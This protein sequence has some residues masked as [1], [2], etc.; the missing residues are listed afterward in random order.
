MKKLE[1]KNSSASKKRSASSKTTNRKSET[2]TTNEKKTVNKNSYYKSKKKT[3]NV[4]LVIFIIIAVIIIAAIVLLFT[5]PVFKV[6]SFT[7]EGT[8]KYTVDEIV[9][10]SGLKVN[11]NIFFQLLKGVS[12][13]INE[14]PYVDSAS[15]KI[16][17]PNK[18]D[19]KIKERTYYFFAFDKEK[20]KFYRI[21]KNGYIMDEANIN[22]KQNDELLVYGFIF[23]NEVVFGT[24]L[25]DV[26][27]SKIVAYENIKNE[28]EKT[29]IEGSITKV[30]FEN[31]L[32]TITLNDKLN[33][34][35][36]ND[37]DVKYKMSFFKSILDKIGEDSVGV[38]DMTKDNPVFSSF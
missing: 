8:E 22:D 37:D 16:I 21:D 17:F 38:I 20:N 31:S 32:T 18:L 12:K 7:I 33:V 27:I 13:N 9:E 2:K 34:I 10:K 25:K 23:D 3:K 24:R 26:D 19:I 1:Y 6:E 28:F 5:L 35:F 11:E 14:L 29:N 15:V 4:K 30:N 36:P